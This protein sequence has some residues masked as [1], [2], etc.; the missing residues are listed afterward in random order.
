MEMKTIK[1]SIAIQAS[2]DK[3]WKVLVDDAYVRIWYAAFSPGCHAVTDWKEGSK[4][5]FID[6][7][8]DGLVGTII[9]NKLFEML[10]VEYY[11]EVIGGQEDLNSKAAQAVKGGRETYVLVDEEGTTLLHIA[12]DMGEEYFES[13][14]A[15]WTNALQKIKE[16]A[17]SI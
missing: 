5:L 11:G 17:E 7:K 16:L 4:A 13:M 1:Q 14:F 6:D 2:R 8:G 10:S 15:C 9:V 12:S 3:V